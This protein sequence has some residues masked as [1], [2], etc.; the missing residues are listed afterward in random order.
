MERKEFTRF[1]K[2]VRQ[3]AKDKCTLLE[4]DFSTPEGK[5]WYVLASESPFLIERLLKKNK[6]GA[7]ALQESIIKYK[8]TIQC[9][10]KYG[11]WVRL[12]DI[13]DWLAVYILKLFLQFGDDLWYVENIYFDKF[14]ELTNV[15]HMNGER[16]AISTFN[17]IINVKLPHQIIRYIDFKSLTTFTGLSPYLGTLD[18]NFD[19]TRF[20]ELALAYSLAGEDSQ[21]LPINF[22]PCSKEGL[23]PGYIHDSITGIIDGR[24][25]NDPLPIKYTY[26]DHKGPLAC[27]D[28]LK[29]C[30]V[31]SQHYYLNDDYVCMEIC[32]ITHDLR[33]SWDDMLL[34][35]DNL[36]A[37]QK[38]DLY[39][40]IYILVG[41]S[42]PSEYMNKQIE[43]AIWGEDTLYDDYP[44]IE[45]RECKISFA[46]WARS[47]L[48]NG[49][50]IPQ[51]IQ[52]IR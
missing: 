36:C 34:W 51:E 39:M 45:V 46:R 3:L 33:T 2:S 20:Y 43:I 11:F 49:R 35:I 41:P 38:V 25:L 22:D 30:T 21:G 14:G 19:R 27:G 31:E 17:G 48:A 47:L 7:W 23:K 15:V 6:Y 32:L 10:L 28:L 24:R 26:F 44:N 16:R 40:T 42:Y 4:L 50:I 5:V 12:R 9:K 18:P 13:I 29:Y 52:R 8:Q 37:I 1:I